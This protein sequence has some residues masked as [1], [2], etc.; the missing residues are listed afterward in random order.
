MN[1]YILGCGALGSNIAMN[2][3]FDR[4]EDELILIDFD[5]I[6]ARNYQFGTQYY[7]PEQEGQS[8]VNALAF[9]MYK[10]AKNHVAERFNMKIDH[11]FAPPTGDD[12]LYVDCFD[13]FESRKIVHDWCKNKEHCL[14]VGFSPQMTFEVS[15]TDNYTPPDDIKS[16][17]DIC[18]AE[19]ARSF[20]QYVSGIATTT[21]IDFIKTGKKR[22]FV[23]NRFSCREVV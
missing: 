14:H 11:D 2:L 8:K 4:R 15:W 12:F 9:N 22:D 21:I 13:N 3:A 18:E 7:F 20:I 17:F 1:I 6:E 19:G 10:V 23:G 5:K 16:D